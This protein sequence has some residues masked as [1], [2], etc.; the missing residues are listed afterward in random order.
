M[1]RDYGQAAVRHYRDAEK[2]AA[3]G[4]HDC[5]GHLIG[6]SAECSLKEAASG[7]TKPPN[8]EI[9]GHLPTLKQS[10]RLILDGRNVKG[11]LLQ[12]VCD[13]TLFSDWHINDRYEA[14]GKVD[15]TRYEQWRVQAQ[16]SL[17][18]AGLKY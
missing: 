10:I 2:L 12:L 1:A 11:K 13:R 16:R 17:S 7:F 15:Q 6:L 9:D 5:A 18:V 14:D 3:T 8:R 4:S